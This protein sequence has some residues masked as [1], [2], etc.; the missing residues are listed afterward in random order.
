LTG[1]LVPTGIVH[2]SY[3]VVGIPE[4]ARMHT[5]VMTGVDPW[6][7]GQPGGANLFATLNKAITARKNIQTQTGTSLAEL[8]T[9]SDREVLGIKALKGGQPIYIKAKKAVVLATGGWI[10]NE[11]MMKA[12]NPRSRW[13]MQNAIL[14][15]T[16]SDESIDGWPIYLATT[17]MSHGEGTLAAMGVGADLFNMSVIAENIDT[18]GG[19]KINPQTQVMDVFGN[20]IPR[21]YAAGLIVGG[22]MGYLDP[23]GGYRIGPSLT[24]GRIAGKN[25]A[26]LK[27][28][29]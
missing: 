20:A 19:L 6:K 23:S 3:D 15:T 27:A 11:K 8:V 10:N 7:D 12:F 28:W 29:A 9:N 24:I 18:N 2:N 4:V 25:V 1:G 5:V 22:I 21:L 16:P 17:D 26:A 13:Y 14:K